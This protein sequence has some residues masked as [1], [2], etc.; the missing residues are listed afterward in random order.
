[1]THVS[2]TNQFNLR[3]KGFIDYEKTF[4]RNG[5]RLGRMHACDGTKLNF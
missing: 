5:N 3:V 4:N 2:Y 1:M